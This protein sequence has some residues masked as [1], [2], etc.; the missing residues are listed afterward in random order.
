M[1]R[2]IIG[3]I[4]L[5]SHLAVCQS[6]GQN[7]VQYRNFNWSFIT[8]PHFDIY[9]YGDGIDLAQFTAE[10]GEEAYE[11]ISKHLR[12]TL[13]K[14]VPIIIYH[15][16]N[17]FQQT[18][19]ILPYMQEGIGGVT[20]LFKNRVVIPFEG[21]YQQFRHVI[22]HE[23]VHAVINDMVYGSAQNVYSGRVRLRVPLWANEGLA[24][25]L[26]MNWDTQAD[27]ILRDLAVHEEMPTVEQLESFL[28]YKGGQSVW[29]FIAEKYGREK[30]GEVFTAMKST[31]DAEKGFEKAIGMDFK[32]LTKQWQKYLKKEY[33]PDINGREE[34]E[35]I[36][37]R[38]TDH[39]EKN[40]YYNISPAISP[41]GS[42]IAIL[43]DKSGFANIS[44]I[45]ATDGK[46]IRK[47]VKGN[48][49]MDFEELKWLQPGISWSPDSRKIVI[50][51][52]AGVQDALY[53]IDVEKPRNREKLTFDLDGIFSAAWSPNGQQ[54]AFVGNKEN[55]SDIYL[56]DLKYKTLINLTNDIYSDSEPVWSSDGTNIAYVSSRNKNENNLAAHD[57]LIFEITYFQTDIFTFD[58]SNNSLQRITDTEANENYPVWANTGNVLFYTSDE[59]GI[60]NLYRHDV[61]NDEVE[62]LTNVLTGL[63]QIS[64]SDNDDVMVFAGYSDNGWDIFRLAN[65]ID[66]NVIEIN[67]TQFIKDIKSGDELLVDFRRNKSNGINTNRT[68]GRD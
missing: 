48:R 68:S 43:E 1:F 51:A 46:N 15:S 50:A 54:I 9:Y 38:L 27:M 59:S 40:N 42:K 28:A 13:R 44:L 5:A 62:P 35:D 60:S 2:V 65:P 39:K 55:A 23:L 24:E 18:N 37:I 26:S 53:L 33:W 7:K 66:M 21:D 11:Q 20:E 32:G 36:A 6:F 16:H 41:D 63:F 45:D 30:I 49:S 3:I 52:K 10:K 4:I 58:I 34:I 14:R 61:D 31:Q 29:R 56:Y 47:L 8:T 22:H 64:L 57:L 12:W 25:Y 67:P 17:D 19:V